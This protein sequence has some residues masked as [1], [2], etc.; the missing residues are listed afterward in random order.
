MLRISQLMEVSNF[1]ND[2]YPQIHAH[3]YIQR[4]REFVQSKV[5]CILKHIV[6][7]VNYKT[8]Q[9]VEEIEIKI[10]KKKSKRL[11]NENGALHDGTFCRWVNK[12]SAFLS[13]KIYLK[14]WTVCISICDASVH[15]D[16]DMYV[17]RRNWGWMQ[18][19][20]CKWILTTTTSSIATMM[21]SSGQIKTTL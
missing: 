14:T 2:I 18:L 16:R 3:A 8:M 4:H 21:L 1:E 9:F 7:I 13:C 6:C 20:G 19:F 5:V 15:I 12:S 11:K 17:K 10:G